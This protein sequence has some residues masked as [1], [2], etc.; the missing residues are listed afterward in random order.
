[1][2]RV[3]HEDANEK[4]FHDAQE[5]VDAKPNLLIL[6]PKRIESS[7]TKVD[8]KSGNKEKENRGREVTLDA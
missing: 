1:M 4:H 7:G 3:V 5:I 8:Q 2:K 6:N